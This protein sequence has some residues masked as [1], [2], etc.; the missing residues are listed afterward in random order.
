MK[1]FTQWIFILS[2]FAL[3]TAC[4]EKDNALFKTI[5]NTELEKLLDEGVT[6]IDIRRPEE[7]KQTGVIKNSKQITFFFGNGQVNPD[8]IPKFQQLIPNKDQPV[9]LICRTG[10]R[11]K[12]AS[13]YLAKSLGY[14]NIYNIKHGITGW[15]RENRE[16]VKYNQ[17][18]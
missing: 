12:A 9:M 18:P 14:T 3:I 1:K 5:G 16:V 13:N 10:N 6:L 15:I 17:N 11:T 2:L 7:W 8:F 4:G